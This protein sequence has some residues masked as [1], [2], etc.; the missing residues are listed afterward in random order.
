MACAAIR[1]RRPGAQ[2]L[3]LAVSFGCARR[4]SLVRREA[5][6]KVP[7][8]RPCEIARMGAAAA[9]K[10][11][12]RN[13]GCRPSASLM[14]PATLEMP[15][16]AGG[17]TSD[18]IRCSQIARLGTAAVSGVVL[19]VRLTEMAGGG[20]RLVRCCAR[21]FRLAGAFFFID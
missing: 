9:L 19:P 5:R 14:R 15:Q 1:L 12:L 2:V 6:R 10:A 16:R 13:S 20:Y 21:C 3:Y 8:P 18:A 11:R 17:A 4:D 7:V